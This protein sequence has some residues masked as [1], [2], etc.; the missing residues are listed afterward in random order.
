MKIHLYRL[1]EQ[2]GAKTVYLHGCVGACG[3]KVWEPD[4]R[5]DRCEFCGSDRYDATGKP[6]EYVVHFPLHDRLLSLLKCRQYTDA[7]RWEHTRTQNA[8]YVTGSFKQC[9][10]CVPFRTHAQ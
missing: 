10:S 8:D 4:D 9:V 6:R 7:L 2:A 5:S 1:F 3:K